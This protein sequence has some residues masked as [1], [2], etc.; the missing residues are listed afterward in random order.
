MTSPIA[1]PSLGLQDLTVPGVPGPAEGQG[2]WKA[3]FF[4]GLSAVC[5][6]SLRVHFFSNGK[7]S[8]FKKKKTKVV[9]LYLSALFSMFVQ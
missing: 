2:F 8:L 3:L 4:F 7:C 5:G 9:E 6:C 1:V